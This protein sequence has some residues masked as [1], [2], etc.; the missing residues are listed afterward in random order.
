MPPLQKYFEQFHQA[1]RLGSYDENE[2]LRE[3]REILLNDLKTGLPQLFE[4][5]KTAPRYKAVNLGSYAL[6]VGVKPLDGNYDIDIGIIFEIAPEDY[7]DPREVKKWV[8]DALLRHNREV[9]WRSPCITVFYAAGYHVDLSV[10]AGGA[11]GTLHPR[12][13]ARGKEH[14]AEENRGWEDA[15]PEKLVKLI[16][17][18]HSGE[19]AAQF[20]RVIRALKRWKQHSFSLR[21]ND[22]PPSVSIV[23][24]AYKWFSPVKSCLDPVQFTYQYDDCSALQRLVSNMLS[25]SET[26]LDGRLKITLPVQPGDDVLRRMTTK[27]MEGFIDKL[28]SLKDSL[29]RASSAED[30]ESA[31]KILRKEFGDDFPAEPVESK[32]FSSP[33]YVGSTQGA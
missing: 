14:S 29:S 1:I 16:R 23:L 27:Q 32:T 11:S 5:P 3:K 2:T 18:A 9:S 33:G 25:Q 10:M 24:S 28:K 19:D 17:N 6:N 31:L 8:R 15:E 26:S 12:A 7:P 21:G 4:D 20:R 13:L 30:T 22:A